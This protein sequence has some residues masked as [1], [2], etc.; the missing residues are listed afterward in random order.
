MDIKYNK[1]NWQQITMEQIWWNKLVYP[2]YFFN[3]AG[4][5]DFDC[6]VD[7]VETNYLD[8][9]LQWPLISWFPRQ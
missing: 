8:G 5:D 7:K 1:S 3:E 6:R 9:S 2:D 4:K